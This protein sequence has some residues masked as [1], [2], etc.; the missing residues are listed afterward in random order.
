MTY[1]QFEIWL[2]DLNPRAGTEPGKVR[3]VIVVQTDL[4]KGHPSTIICPITTNVQNDSEILRI[5]LKKTMSKL[6]EDCDIILDQIR[7]IDNTRFIKK[8]GVLPENL[9]PKLKENLS[10]ILDLF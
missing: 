6:K 10:I 8:L 1:K 9:R 5:H 2:A 4:L 3:P 7:A